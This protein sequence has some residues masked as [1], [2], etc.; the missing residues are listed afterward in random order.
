VPSPFTAFALVAVN[1]VF[2]LHG[3]AAIYTPPVGAAV[4]CTV[5]LD[6][7]DGG[8]KPEDGRPLAGQSTIKVRSSDVALPENGGT[9][10]PGET[11]NGTFGPG[12]ATFTVVNRPQIEDPD[13]LV[14]TMW[15][16]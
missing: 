2:K 16:E 3:V 13:G 9:F 11:V 15:V 1:E 10:V 8:A 6:R 14:W 5:I 7:R 12:P 4:P